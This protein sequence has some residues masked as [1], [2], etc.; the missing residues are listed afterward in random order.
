MEVPRSD[1]GL[2]RRRDGR[3]VLISARSSRSALS[4][5]RGASPGPPRSQPGGSPGDKPDCRFRKTATGYDR[6]PGVKWLSCTAC[7]AAI[8]GHGGGGWPGCEGGGGGGVVEEA[9]GG[10]GG[11]EVVRGGG[12]PRPA[13]P[14]SAMPWTRSRSSSS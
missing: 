12:P 3:A 7:E 4:P 1:P 9:G 5:A 10:R 11:E 14:P 13:A 2:V 8:P 6:K